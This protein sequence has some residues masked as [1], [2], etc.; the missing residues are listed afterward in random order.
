MSSL[1]VPPLKRLTRPTAPPG[2]RITERDIAI[3]IAVAR[4]RFLTSQQIA[5][6]VG[7]SA[8]AMLVRLKLLFYHALLD[9]PSHQH[10]Q[11]AM[12]FDEGNRPLVYGLGRKGAR[13]LAELGFAVD[14][15]LDWTTKN[16][17]ATGQFLA[18]TIEIADVMIEIDLAVRAE[19]HLRLIDHHD[20]VPYFP[21]ERRRLRDPFRCR[22]DVRVPG[23]A[24]GI[25]IAVVP[26]RLFSIAYPDAT[27]HN[28]AVELD[29]G[30]MDINA[31]RLVGKSSFRRKLLGYFHAWR[32]H[33][34]N[35]AW[36]FKSF[37]IL[38][39]APSDKRIANMITA[40]NEVT[41]GVAPGLFL[42]STPEAIAVDGALGTAWVNGAGERVSLIA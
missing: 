3:L 30:S 8:Q 31:K 18:H 40:Q 41:D 22:V 1:L 6:L 5:R 16:A 29:R 11:L 25:S 35:D 17:R 15:R 21:A 37:R 12:F 14:G 19:A 36:G 27:R 33:K 28:Y 26:D 7:G 9:R 20:L 24:T 2:L 42:Y 10:S 32:A 34:T 4:F 39:V 23:H 38:T 13:L